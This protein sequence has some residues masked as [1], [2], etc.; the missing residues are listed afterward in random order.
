MPKLSAIITCVPVTVINGIFAIVC[1]AIVMN[2]LKVIQN[3]VINDRNMMIIGLPILLTVGTIVL[4]AEILNSVPPF[5]NYILSSGTAVGAIAAVILNLV[6][7][8]EQNAKVPKVKE[9]TFHN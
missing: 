5:V 6:I 3:V 4:P 1:V 9:S 2:G 7:P 8:E